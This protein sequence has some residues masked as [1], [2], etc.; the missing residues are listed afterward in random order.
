VGYLEVIVGGDMH[1]EFG[2]WALVIDIL[3]AG[4]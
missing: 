2:Y 3:V 1:I 4:E